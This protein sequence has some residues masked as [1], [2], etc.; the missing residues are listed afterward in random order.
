LPKITA[1]GV[2]LHYEEIGDRHAPALLLIMGLGTQLIAWPDDFRRDLAAA[3]FRVIAFDNR[4]IGLS[5]TLDDAP[6]SHLGW[7]V[8]ASR[9][10]LRWQ[11]PYTLADMAGD[12]VALLD[13]LDIAAAHIVGASMGGMIA[14]HLAAAHPDRVLS[15]TSIMSTSGAPGLP[16]PT[17]ALRR[18]LLSPRRRDPVATTA[19]LLER[20]SFPDPARPPGAFVAMAERAH[21]RAWNPR[22][23]TRHLLAILAD[24]SRAD[25]LATITAPTLVVHGA[26]DPLIPP[27]CGRDTAARIPGARFELIEAMAHDL[28]PSQMPRLAQLIADHA[29]ASDKA[30]RVDIDDHADIAGYRDAA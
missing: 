24:G 29:T 11:P 12:A 18:R 3:G 21:G 19:E 23:R 17:P 13:A 26:H 5:A 4:D 2:A 28:P 14:Q 7:A 22:A 25:R 16:G 9:F 8:L 6:H 20:T 15:L 10:G 30:V 27:A 1:N